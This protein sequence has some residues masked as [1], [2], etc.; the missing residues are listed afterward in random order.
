[1]EIAVALRKL[2]PA[3]WRV[4]DYARLLVNVQTLAAVKRADEPE[5]IARLW[6]DDLAE[7][8]RARASALLYR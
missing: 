2:Y 6:A 7:F 4:D 1:L 5:A 8:R 3:E